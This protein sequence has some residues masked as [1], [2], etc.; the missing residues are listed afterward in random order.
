MTDNKQKNRT[1]G[2]FGII[3]ERRSDGVTGPSRT[4]PGDTSGAIDDCNMNNHEQDVEFLRIAH[5]QI[6][7][8]ASSSGAADA[9]ENIQ[10]EDV[11]TLMMVPRQIERNTCGST[12]DCK[13][14]NQQQEMKIKDAPPRLVE[15]VT[16]LR[17]LSICSAKDSKSTCR[18]RTERD[19][20]SPYA[21]V[22]YVKTE[23]AIRALVCSLMERQDRMNK[24][25]FLKLNDLKY[26]FDDL[27]LSKKSRATKQPGNGNEMRK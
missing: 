3:P 13:K 7:R 18:K 24:E 9:E 19:L 27:E 11:K 17:G 8:N 1:G 22:P 25:I 4:V 14:N 5:R 15:R 2:F 21:E 16:A 23:H 12:D 20:H 6:E 26:R 10:Q